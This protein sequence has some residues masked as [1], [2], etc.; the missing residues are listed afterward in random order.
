MRIIC[1][2]NVEFIEV[3][4]FGEGKFLNPFYINLDHI[5]YIREYTDSTKKGWAIFVGKKMLTTFDDLGLNRCIPGDMVKIGSRHF[6]CCNGGSLTDKISC[7]Y[8]VNHANVLY[9]RKYIE[10]D[11][12]EKKYKIDRKDDGEKHK[13]AIITVDERIIPA[14]VKLNDHATA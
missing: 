4:T 7:L 1:K 12:G 8:F 13:F 14:D 5:R 6:E 3:T 11:K 10:N 9:I 2:G